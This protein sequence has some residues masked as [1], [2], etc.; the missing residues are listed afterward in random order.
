[1][2]GL[3]SLF[4]L[5]SAVLAV[6]YAD[7]LPLPR[8]NPGQPGFPTFPGGTPPFNPYPGG[9]GPFN[10]RP[11]LPDTLLVSTIVFLKLVARKMQS[12]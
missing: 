8:P 12:S 6:S 11:D 1:M 9:T 7:L 3:L 10:P 2:T 5:L 4:M